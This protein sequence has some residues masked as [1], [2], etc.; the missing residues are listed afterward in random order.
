M[1]SV[2]HVLPGVWTAHV[3][4]ERTPEKH[5]EAPAA[6]AA[7]ASARRALGSARPLAQNVDTVS[8]PS[9]VAS[10]VSSVQYGSPNP[11]RTSDP[12]VA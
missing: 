2:D 7:G 8:P 4:F 10:T 3:I 5:K 6:P 11:R 1:L 12:Y 9:V